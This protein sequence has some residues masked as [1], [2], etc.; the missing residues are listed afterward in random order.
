MNLINR[1][2]GLLQQRML[3]KLECY[4]SSRSGA[5]LPAVSAMFVHASQQ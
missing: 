3:R 5:E 1:A 4:V 2:I